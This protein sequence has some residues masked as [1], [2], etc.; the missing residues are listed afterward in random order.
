MTTRQANSRKRYHL[1]RQDQVKNLHSSFRQNFP[2][3]IPSSFLG[4]YCAVTVTAWYWALAWLL[5]MLAISG[6]RLHDSKRLQNQEKDKINWDRAMFRYVALC[7]ASSL[8]WAIHSF[9]FFN[10]MT[11]PHQVTMMLM[12]SILA[13]GAVYSVSASQLVVNILNAGYLLPVSYLKIIEQ[14]DTSIYGYCGVLYA[15]SM[16]F[17]TS[18]HQRRIANQVGTEKQNRRLM[19]TAVRQHGR[20]YSLNKKL[21]ATQD[22]LLELNQQLELRVRQRTNRLQLEIS[23]RE[24]VQ[25]ELESL[26]TRDPLTRLAN[27]AKLDAVLREQLANADKK[28][29]SVALFFIDLDRF[30]EINDGLGHDVGDR[31][32]EIIAKRLLNHAEGAACVAR[33][34]GDEFIIVQTIGLASSDRLEA[35]ASDLASHVRGPIQLGANTLKVGASVG[36]ALYPTHGK[37][38]E[39]LI[40]HADLAVYQAKLDGR[41][42]ARLFQPIWQKEAKDR[43]D[44]V[45]ALKGAIENDELTL[46]YQPIV[47]P[48]D[49]HIS[50][51]ETLLRWSHPTWGEVAPEI[52]VRL[53]EEN[54]LMVSLGNWVL[55]H[56]GRAAKT[57]IGPNCPCV[58]INVSIQQFTNGDFIGVLDTV[59]AENKLQ[60]SSIEIEITESIYARDQKDVRKTLLAIRQRGVGIAIDD[61]GTGYSSLAYLQQFP[62]DVLKVDRSFV[63]S[64]DSG[65]DSIIG[66]VASMATS[67]GVKVVVEGIESVEELRRVKQLGATFVQGFLFSHPM[68]L[69]EASEWIERHQL[70]TLK[71]GP[72]P[73]SAVLA[74]PD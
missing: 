52:F 37:D 67:L 70:R 41:G 26:A 59:L 47:N 65:G 56:A 2:F 64:L 23:E 58:T 38:P 36:I 31:V 69:A 12:F 4:T 25:Q 20:L 48:F 22:S 45:K 9:L 7:G 27:R 42:R 33:W 61:F 8:L 49:G 10:D 19:Q 57:L 24:G 55:R 50:A 39:S 68:P 28:V 72:T 34:G 1:T 40:R 63:A 11:T 35:Y 29:Q 32:L 44:M 18:S 51:M 54:G 71:P 13:T 73:A 15:L 43:L 14:N 5:A 74:H 46:V 60:P 3:V 66:A 53:A 30:K 62:V 21:Q 17:W 6:I 16:A